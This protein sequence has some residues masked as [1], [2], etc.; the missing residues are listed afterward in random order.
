[1]VTAAPS[2][3]AVTETKSFSATAQA[4]GVTQP[5]L[6]NK[7]AKLEERLGGKLFE[8]MP[9]GVTETA[10]G[11][12]VLPLVERAASALDV[13]AVKARRLTE[14]GGQRI[15]QGRLGTGRLLARR[16]GVP[17]RTRPHRTTRTRAARGRHGGTTAM[18]AP[19][20]SP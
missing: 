6:S 20:S 19:G 14:P 1:M 18:P 11:A 7:I 9:R 17:C 12:E 3:Q 4:Y 13:V 16:L 15:R 5:A 2:A 10:G 8:R